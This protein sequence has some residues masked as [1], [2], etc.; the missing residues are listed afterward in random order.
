MNARELI[1]ILAK[2]DPHLPL[3][4]FDRD[5]QKYIDVAGAREVTASGDDEPYRRGVEIKAD[6][7]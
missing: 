4:I 6:E 7:A 1:A 3:V 5:T 2:F